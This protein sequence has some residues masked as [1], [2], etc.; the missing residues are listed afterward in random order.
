MRLCLSFPPQLTPT[1]P[2]LGI[3]L[4]KS[5]IEEELGKK[6][7]VADLNLDF[8]DAVADNYL[9]GKFSL[10][11]NREK[12]K[13]SVELIRKSISIFR[14]DPKGSSESISSDFFNPSVYN[15]CANEFLYL[16]EKVFDANVPLL[17]GYIEGKADISGSLSPFTGKIISKR[18][19]IIGFSVLTREQIYYA[20][21]IAKELKER[22][23]PKI[24]IGGAAV[25]M[26]PESFLRYDFIDLVVNGDGENA[27][28]GVM[29][30]KGREDISNIIYKKDGKIIRNRE[31]NIDINEMPPP[32]FSGF[33]LDGYFCP[34][35]VLTTLASRGCA[36]KRC[37]FCAD[38]DSRA[39][40]YRPKKIDKL[41]EELRFLKEKYKA[42][43]FCFA[44]EMASPVIFRKISERMIEEKL[45]VRYYIQARPK[46]FDQDILQKMK[47]SGCT[48]ILWGVESACQRV[49]DL[50]GKGTEITEVENILKESRAAGIRN[51]VY[52]FGGFPTETEEEYNKTIRWLDRNRDL[53]DLQFTGLF[54]LTRNSRIEKNISP[55]KISSIRES[56]D[57]FDPNY[58][59]EVNEGISQQRSIEL[60]EK[61]YT[62]FLGLNKFSPFLGKFR[63][64]LLVC[65]DEDLKKDDGRKDKP[66]HDNKG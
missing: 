27:L 41:I 8:Y 63:D 19:D 58:D 35:R 30:G 59:Y 32:D 26:F 17:K 62:F 56:G 12:N 34:A 5:C 15:P 37:S 38:Y 53:I 65:F 61:N 29:D 7:D 54:R 45:G 36:W 51:A 52:A 40:Q 33:D 11:D 22:I 55:F 6:V 42:R 16:F 48:S 43:F 47:K 25:R 23:A 10:Y 3:A 50:I 31:E 9:K 60:F 20:L 28:Q 21:A 18:P 2:P 14:H 46:G 57:I 24:I 49:L 39:M 13:R 1:S 64:H 4:L 44:D 66:V